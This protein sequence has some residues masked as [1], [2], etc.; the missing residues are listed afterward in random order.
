MKP[1]VLSLL[2][3]AS[4]AV[5]ATVVPPLNLSS[6]DLALT[7]LTLRINAMQ[8]RNRYFESKTN[9]LEREMDRLETKFLLLIILNVSVVI[10]LCLL[11]A[12]DKAKNRPPK[13][14]GSNLGPDVAG[15]HA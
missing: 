3:L 11:V 6:N 9:R 7:S 2:L 15:D 13:D 5:S 4:T 12:R 14:D 8:Q 10:S 1:L